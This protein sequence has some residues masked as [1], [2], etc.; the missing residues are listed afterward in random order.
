VTVEADTPGDALLI[1]DGYQDIDDFDLSTWCE[2]DGERKVYN[3]DGKEY[4][5]EEDEDS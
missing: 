5:P 1:A 4:V 2:H 3:V